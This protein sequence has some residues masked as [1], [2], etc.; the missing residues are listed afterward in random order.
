MIVLIV[1]PSGVGKTT[2]F[3]AAQSHLPAV[4]FRSLDSLVAAWGVKNGLIASPR[5]A[6][7]SRA[8]SNP[9]LFLDIGLLAIGQLAGRH[10]GRHLVVDVGAGFQVAVTAQHLHRLFRLV[11]VVAEPEVAYARIKAA[12]NDERTREQY[13]KYE[14][15]PS[16]AAVYNSAQHSI[17]T[18]TQTVDQTCRQFVGLLGEILH[19]E[20][21]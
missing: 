18:T 4:V 10:P 3:K 11:A 16:R 5:I 13:L 21:P 1:G 8:L 17:D 14:Y 19:S 9:E 15:S 2:C 6:V 7:L 12:R 20:F